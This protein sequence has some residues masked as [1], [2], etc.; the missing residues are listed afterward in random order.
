MPVKRLCTC[1]LILTS[2]LGWHPLHAQFNEHAVAD[3]YLQYVPIAAGIGLGWAGVKA[4]DPG[5]D[6]IMAAGMGFVAE[7]VIVNAIKYT[8][9]EERPDGSARNSFP[10]GHSATAFLGA[11]IVRREYGWGW[12]AGAYAVAGSV[13]VLRVC[14]HRHYWWDTVAGAGCGV[15]SACIG[16]SLLAPAHRLL[17]CDGRRNPVAELSMSP[18]YDPVSG[19]VGPAFALRFQVSRRSVL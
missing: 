8:V 5:W 2:L 17:G 4:L 11:E 10:S 15:L 14:H 12:G 19:A 13:A 16:Y 1:L 9:R 7:S 6:R 3:Y 18:I